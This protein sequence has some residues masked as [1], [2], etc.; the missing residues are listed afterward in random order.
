MKKLL[1]LLLAGLMLLTLCAC[2]GETPAE[3]P[4]ATEASGTEVGAPTEEANVTEAPETEL[5]TEATEE[6]KPAATEISLNETI[7]LEF[8]EITFEEY[9]IAADIQ[10]SIKSGIVTRITGPEPENGKQFV[11]LRG[12]IKNVHKE[13]LPT[14]DFFTGE[15]DIDGYKYDCSANQCDILNE[16]G[17]TQWEIEPLTSY[18][19]TM[20]AKIPDELANPGSVSFRFGFYDLFDNY[21]LSYNR[22]FED[23]PIAL[24]PYQYALT[25]AE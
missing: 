13:A 16:N 15:F 20:Y 4:A 19:F 1:A 10:Q 9:G 22:S 2:A 18:S 6:P 14:Y 3:V 24:C 5:V 7:Q 23:D 12:T 25:L 8:V 21:E 11:Y 17:E